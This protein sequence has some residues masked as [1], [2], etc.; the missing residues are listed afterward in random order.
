M[1]PQLNMGKNPN[2]IETATS[3]N[4]WMWHYSKLKNL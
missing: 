3:A 4:T 2:E 1:T